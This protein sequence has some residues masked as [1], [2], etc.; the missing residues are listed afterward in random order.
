[1]R[2]NINPKK[3]TQKNFKKFGD[4]MYASKTKPINICTGYARRFNSMCRNFAS[5]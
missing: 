5:L 3:I 4:L 1:M 2:M